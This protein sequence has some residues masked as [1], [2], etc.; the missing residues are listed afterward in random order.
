MRRIYNIFI[1]LFFL[2]WSTS[3]LA[4]KQGKLEFGT[5]VWD[6]GTI[7]E[8]GGTVMK[9]FS[10]RNHGTGTS[11]VER[12]TVSCNCLKVYLGEESF[13]PGES[14]ELTVSFSPTGLSGE[15]YK[16]VTIFTNTPGEKIVLGIKGNVVNQ[17]VDDS[18][19]V[20][21]GAGLR[22]RT[23]DLDYGNIYK[24]E[25]FL[26][27]LSLWNTSGKEVS[28]KVG[29]VSPK[30]KVFGEGVIPAG[31]KR[32]VEIVYDIPAS[33]TYYGSLSGSLALV[34]DGVSHS[35]KISL[36]AR[37][38]EKTSR[39]ATSKPRMEVPAK[40]LSFRKFFW[41]KEASGHFSLSNTGN[42]EL[43]IRKVELSGISECSLKSGSVVPAGKTARVDVSLSGDKGYICLFTNDPVRPFIEMSAVSD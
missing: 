17:K 27:S 28:V 4:Q 40:D 8:D 31:E 5:P 14:G 30:I 3:A 20:D 21:L 34:V 24:G 19:V 32:D 38:I 23:M 16:T 39:N 18:Y 33:D 11:V 6:F 2:F 9:A 22:A 42:A 35:R 15:Q 1:L 25:K 41:Q 43:I 29:G 26:R 37:C 12:V 36:V 13:D 7:R 10:F